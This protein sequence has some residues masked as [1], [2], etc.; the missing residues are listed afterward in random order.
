MEHQFTLRYTY[1]DGRKRMKQQQGAYPVQ[2]ASR[3]QPAV[4]RQHQPPANPHYAGHSAG[5]H[6]EDQP[7]LSDDLEEDDSY[8]ETRV[9]TSARRYVEPQPQIIQHGN[10]RLVIH[11]E[12]PPRRLRY[13]WLTYVGLAM[14]I[15]LLGWMLVTML[16]VWWQA[17]QDDWSYGHPR[18]YQIDANVGHGS[19]QLP[20]SHF[21]AVNLNG[22][23]QV[24][25]EPGTDA[26]KA[27]IYNITTLQSGSGDIPVSLTFR[28]INV[29][30]KIDMLVN[31]GDSGNQFTIFLFNNGTQFVS[32]L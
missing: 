20:M 14:I 29:D 21:I 7:F 27:H 3:Q 31:I 23:V 1:D 6:P 8:Y 12:P 2:R 17:K 16:G 24:L 18:T 13:H 22:V 15:M 4:R 32:K 11:N 28:D 25:E 9:P 5:I 10:K 19:N 26:S 30:G